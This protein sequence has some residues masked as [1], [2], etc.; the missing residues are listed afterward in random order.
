[1]CLKLKKVNDKC[2][3]TQECSNELV[4]FKNKC[5]K[6]RSLDIGEDVSNIESNK[7]YVSQICK[8]GISYKGKCAGKLYNTNNTKNYNQLI[9]CNI[10]DMCNYFIKYNQDNAIEVY[11]SEECQC[12]FNTHSKGY[13]P[14][15]HLNNKNEELWE[16]Y[17]ESF[18]INRTKSNCHTLNRNCFIYYD[19]YINTIT[20]NH[21]KYKEADID[22]KKAMSNMDY[23]IF[24]K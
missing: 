23:N 16:A 9:E 18:I 22:S 2:L 14:L 15:S 1:M 17:N 12:G 7:Y 6:Y 20:I 8:F 3:I 24:F 13:C 19:E 21:M 4:C 11:D 5:I 10:Y